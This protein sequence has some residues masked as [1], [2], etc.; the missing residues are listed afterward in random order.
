[1]DTSNAN[2]LN[3][4]KPGNLNQTYGNSLYPSN[5]TG[6]PQTYNRYDID[7]HGSSVKNEKNT[8]I[9]IINSFDRDKSKYPHPNKYVISLKNEYRDV[10]AV[11]LTSA[12]FPNSG[13]IVDSNNNL[14]HFQD[15]QEDID[16]SRVRIARI[17]PG[18]WPLDSDSGPT[19]SD[20]IEEAMNR[21]ASEG[22]TYTVELDMY[23]RKFTIS[24]DSGG[25]GVLNLIFEGRPMH[26]DTN[27]NMTDFFY[28]GCSIGQLIG[29]DRKNQVGSSEYTSNLTYDLKPDRFLVLMIGNLDRLDSYN[30]SVDKGFAIIAQDTT[31]NNFQFARDSD[32]ISNHRYIK[33]FVSPEPKLDR[34]EIEIRTLDGKLYD[35]NGHDHYMTFEIQSLTRVD[36]YASRVDQMR[37]VAPQSV[38]MRKI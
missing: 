37:T 30:D 33:Y 14:L 23:R 27:N 18:D 13:Y 4:G 36:N 16:T 34:F 2:I 22:N 32:G 31:F 7:M 26:M 35:F 8:A 6:Y 1:M 11:E 5:I 3:Y 19:L 29:F 20:K 28:P 17:E 9:L 24:Q 15:S 38:N 12:N 21:E 10:V 25:T